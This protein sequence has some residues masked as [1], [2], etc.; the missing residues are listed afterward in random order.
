MSFRWQDHA[1]HSEYHGRDHPRYQG[2]K[3]GHSA[4][5]TP[6]IALEQEG[7][8]HLDHGVSLYCL[9]TYSS[10]GEMEDGVYLAL[11]AQNAEKEQCLRVGIFEVSHD[12]SKLW[13]EGVPKSK[14]TIF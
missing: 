3:D 5:L 2:E 13:F 14:I 6:D 7:P 8:D 10:R 4:R 9:R 11:R 12:I 1:I